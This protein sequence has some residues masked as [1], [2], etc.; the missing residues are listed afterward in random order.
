MAFP[1]REEIREF[2][3]VPQPAT[4]SLRAAQPRRMYVGILGLG[5]PV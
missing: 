5:R 3:N 2:P 1:V 4:E